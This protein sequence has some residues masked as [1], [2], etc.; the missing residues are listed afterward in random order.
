MPRKPKDSATYKQRSDNGSWTFRYRDELGR[1]RWKTAPT[2]SAAKQ[3]RAKLVLEAKERKAGVRPSAREEERRHLSLAD[4][5][6]R[7]RPDF[8]AKKAATENK[9]Y[10]KIW[11]RDLGDL[12]A[13]QIVPG[14]IESWRR[15]MKLKGMSNATINRYTSF[16]RWLFNVGIRDQLLEQNPLAHGR[17]K[18]LEENDPRD[19]VLTFAEEDRLLPELE[20]VD[21][22]AFVISL[23]AGLRQGEILRLE[24]SD[25]DFARKR[26][27]LRSTKAGKTQWARLNDAALEAVT[28]VMS[29]HEHELLF[30]NESGTGPMSGSRMTD[31]LKSAAEKLGFKNVLFHTGRHTFVTRL[32][33]G[34]HDIGVVKSAARHSTITMTD[35]YMH[36]AGEATEKAV[37]SLCE[38]FTGRGGLFPSAPSARGHLRAL[39]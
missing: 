31:R 15:S 11:K 10:A 39:G 27:R 9:G 7:Y 35:S 26:A 24:R 30:P 14:D 25:I 29:R 5:I 18:P 28:W 19:R 33:S 20:P 16:L 17:I 1:D 34:G 36:T 38:R 2:L 23:Y 22:A 13:N 6:E 37:D 21:R 3:L 4:L 8:E 32:A 12:R